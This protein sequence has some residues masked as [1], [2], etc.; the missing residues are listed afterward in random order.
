M[1]PTEVGWS[2]FK[3][4]SAVIA[5]CFG[6]SARCFIM[7]IL[8]AV[9]SVE[10]SWSCGS[11]KTSA[12]SLRTS[13]VLLPLSNASKC[14]LSAGNILRFNLGSWIQFGS[15]FWNMMLNCLLVAMQSISRLQSAALHDPTQRTSFLRT[16][17][18]FHLKQHGSFNSKPMIPDKILDQPGFTTRRNLSEWYS[19]ILKMFEYTFLHLMMWCCSGSFVNFPL[20]VT[21]A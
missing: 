12:S 11:I 9:C 18:T 3:S 14:A 7:F 1:A 2:F 19:V 8:F 5:L 4:T 13:N 20:K 10:G 17:Q 6:T 21:F 16:L 15:Y